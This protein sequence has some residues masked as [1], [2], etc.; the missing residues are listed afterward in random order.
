MDIPKVLYPSL[1]AQNF[2]LLL[3]VKA[4]PATL[5]LVF[6]QEDITAEGVVIQTIV[7]MEEEVVVVLLILQKRVAHYPHFL[8]KLQLF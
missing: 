8:Q 6:L 7:H 2:I 3:A 4:Q 1:P 5:A